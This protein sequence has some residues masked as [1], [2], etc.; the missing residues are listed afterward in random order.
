[1]I[2]VVFFGTPEVSTYSLKALIE[3]ERFDVVAVV[4]QPPK[5][6]GRRGTVTKSHVHELADEF[7]IPVLTPRKSKEITDDLRDIAADVHVV[8][9]FGQILPKELVDMPEH[10]TINIH[11]SLLP[12]WRG[13]APVPATILSGDSETGVSIMLMDEKMDHGPILDV[14]HAP[15]AG[16]TADVLLEELMKTGAKRLVEILPKH[17]AGSI[18][19]V[20]QLHEDATFCKM[21]K[22]ED[23]KIRWDLPLDEIERM[24]R[25]YSPWPGSWTEISIDNKW[26]RLKIL[27]V[28]LNTPY[29]PTDHAKGV[30]IDTDNG[31]HV[32]SLVID[33]LQI[34][35]KRPISGEE[36]AATRKG[37]SYEVRCHCDQCDIK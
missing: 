3:D 7:N 26:K 25:A 1:M 12:R 13:A 17:V 20:A 5:P 15:V 9:A 8:V 19:P 21:L 24:I 11:P 4:T 34:E 22:R 29:V 16:K 14:S 6:V 37:A 31:T 33:D 28:H 23:A 10:G 30:T 36:F 35:G 18:E 27:K 2:R 32:G